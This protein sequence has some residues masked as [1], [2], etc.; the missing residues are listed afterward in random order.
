MQVFVGFLTFINKVPEIFVLIHY[1]FLFLRLLS[2]ILTVY[3]FN[4]YYLSFI[5][6]IIGAIF[7]A[8]TTF[9]SYH[10]LNR[11]FHILQHIHLDVFQRSSS[12][13]TS[14]DGA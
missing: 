7:T 4:I 13:L 5:H 8:Q 9:I 14:Y 10:D 1:V 2:T 6:H 12:S 11:L 3:V